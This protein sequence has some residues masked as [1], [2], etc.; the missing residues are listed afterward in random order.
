MTHHIQSRSSFWIRIELDTHL[1][2]QS[3]K[4]VNNEVPPI[5]HEMQRR[6]CEPIPTKQ[7]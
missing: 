4:Q 5:G 6:N 7:N 1:F 3:Q 2:A